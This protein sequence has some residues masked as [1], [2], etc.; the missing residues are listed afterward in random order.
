[1]EIIERYIH[2]VGTYLPR[3]MR[4]DVIEELRSNLEEALADRLEGGEWPSAEEAEIALLEE[5][6]PPH[7]LADSYVPRP[8]V[9]FGP[10]L[11]PPFILTMKIVVGAL[12]ALA[13]LRLVLGLSRSMSLG[14]LIGAL[15]GAFA[16]VLTGSLITLGI[17]VVVFALIERTAV[18]PVTEKERWDPRALPA[19][20]DPDTVSLGEAVAPV[21]FLTIALVALNV[22]RDRL[23]VFVSIGEERGW[24]P[25][26]GPAFDAQ[27]W[28]LNIALVLDL[29]VNFLVLVRR[30]WTTLLRSAN[31]VTNALYVVW[32]WQIAAG[33][34]IIEVDPEW[35]IENGWSAESAA[36]YH[37]TIGTLGGLL[38]KGLR[39]G[40][41]AAVAGL[42]F[43]L[44]K[45][46]WRLFTGPGPVRPD[47]S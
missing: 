34:S 41:Y 46:I 45:L 17:V 1:M 42:I 4:D 25:I 37:E 10:R 32:L 44:G 20:D 31:L 7:Q 24:V 8:R 35:M 11:Y 39:I 2:E 43:Q 19:V 26:L 16:G 33:P 21:V 36:N 18:L 30:R 9:L 47:R 28:L 5:L 6:G 3:Q 23:G 38:S 14:E 22:F 29:V 27:M 40:S 15:F 12:A 13:V